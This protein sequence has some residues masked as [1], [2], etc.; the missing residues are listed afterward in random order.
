MPET[1]LAMLYPTPHGDKLQALLENE[2]LPAD[3]RPRVEEAIDRYNRWL[4][5]IEGVAGTGDGSVEP[6]SRLL[7]SYKL[8]IDL[9]LVFDSQNDFLYRQKGQLKIDNTILE[10]FLPRLVGSVFAD[11]LT[12]RG[13]VLGPA[14]AFSQLRFDSNLL[15]TTA[16]GG[17]AV[18]SKD[19]DFAMARPLFLKASHREDFSEIREARTNLA[20]LAAEIKTNLDKTMFQEASG[21]AYDLKL[22]LPNSRYFLLCEWLDMTP[23]STAVTAIEEVIVLRKARRLS[24][25]VRQQFSTAAGR[26]V[27]RDAFMRYLTEHPLSPVAFRRFLSHVDALLGNGDENERDALD[28]GWF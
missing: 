20:Y 16:G 11:R 13:L 15:S 25:H 12:E 3:D 28:R 27:N 23:I 21:T 5:D 24:A 22:S 7:N 18:R 19:H 14:N 17:M 6:L 26:S 2:K 8:S 1:R 9:E 4:V 10:E